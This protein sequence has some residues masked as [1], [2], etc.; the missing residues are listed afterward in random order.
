[1]PTNRWIVFG[2][3]FAAIAGP[4]PLVGPT[5]AAQFGYLPGVLWILVGAVLGGCV[6]D[7]TILFLSTRRDGT[8]PRPDGARRT[9][10]ASAAT[11]R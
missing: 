7:M 2:H 9:R 10:P 11:P 6:Q 5:L 1:M 3:H 8:Q 4:G